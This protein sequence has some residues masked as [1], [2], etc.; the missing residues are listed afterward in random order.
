[1]FVGLDPMSKSALLN[2]AARGMGSS[3]QQ[4]ARRADL[5]RADLGAGG[6]AQRK[7]WQ[8][9]TASLI[10]QFHLPDDDVQTVATDTALLGDVYEVTQGLFGGTYT[11][12]KA[13]AV[14]TIRS[15]D[16]TYP[17]AVRKGVGAARTAQR[18][19]NG[20]PVH[21]ANMPKNP[22]D[23]MRAQGAPRSSKTTQRRKSSAR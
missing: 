19:A 13:A 21:R 2:G 17:D 5:V 1:M 8:K 16:G 6:A 9:V 18:I 4:I 20:A 3:V 22:A 11:L 7:A 15:G 14:A 23:A 10:G 12:L